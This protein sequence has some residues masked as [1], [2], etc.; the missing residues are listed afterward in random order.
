MSFAQLMNANGQTCNF[1][2]SHCWSH[3]FTK[4]LIALNSAAKR[5][6]DGETTKVAFW[7]CLFALNQHDLDG[8]LGGC[9]LARMPF[10]YGLS[11]ALQGV[12][13][14]LDERAEP[15]RRIWCLYE[16]WYR[17]EEGLTLLACLEVQRA[18]EL[19]K[20]LRLITDC[21]EGEGLHI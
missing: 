15:F 3:P 6:K 14:V 19:D 9:E 17:T 2:V 7:I 12:V 1:F 8:E 21:A 10:A 11:K 16:A 5:W 20:D 4:T 13:M 18:W